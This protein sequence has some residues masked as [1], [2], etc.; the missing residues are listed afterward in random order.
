MKILIV[1]K[2]ILFRNGLA[3]MLSEVPGFSII[4]G[5]GTA[6]DALAKT[7]EHNPDVILMNIRLPDGNGLDLIKD[8]LYRNPEVKIV[9]LSEQEDKDYF[10]TAIRNG[11]RGF[12][13]KNIP[14][15]DLTTSIRNLNSG[16][17]AITREMTKDLVDEIQRTG[18]ISKSDIIDYRALTFR[19]TEVLKLLGDGLGNDKI[20]DLLYISP[21]TVR[22]HVH[23]IL[24][25]LNL[26]NR[27][28][29]YH[30]INRNNSS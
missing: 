22:V 23:R 20:A 1:D 9:I 16:Q 6:K 15:S 27:R 8:I 24:K 30:F 19:E 12:L 29:A 5:A 21:N 28:E 18:K 26:R 3:S 2:H 17:V 10:L 7:L 25:K 11:A 4:D 13:N 14:L